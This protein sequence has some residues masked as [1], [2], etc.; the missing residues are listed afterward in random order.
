MELYK[1]KDWNVRDF[2]R[3]A[4]HATETGTGLGRNVRIELVEESGNRVQLQG[5]NL[6]PHEKALAV[7]MF[8]AGV[9]AERRF[10]GRGEAE[11]TQS[12]DAPAR[13]GDTIRVTMPRKIHTSQWSRV[14]FGENVLEGDGNTIVVGLTRMRGEKLLPYSTIGNEEELQDLLSTAQGSQQAGYPRALAWSPAWGGFYL[15]GENLVLEPFGLS[16]QSSRVHS[17]DPGVVLRALSMLIP[18][19]K[20]TTLSWRVFD[21]P[22]SK[23]PVLKIDAQGLRAFVMCQDESPVKWFSQGS[24]ST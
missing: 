5:R 24:L 19:S 14:A 4:L 3:F 21:H 1:E 16:G 17:F 23:L 2:G 10:A 12:V 7:E 20:P 18:A 9:A 15:G 11:A 22:S 8:T 13:V 6:G